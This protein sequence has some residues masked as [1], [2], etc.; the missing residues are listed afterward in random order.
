M[1]V[2]KSKNI[3]ANVF[4]F[5]NPICYKK[6]GR[7]LLKIY[8]GKVVNRKKTY[9]L[10]LGRVKLGVFNSVQEAKDFNIN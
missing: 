6:V 5:S 9:I 7:K 8:T 1:N 3:K 2:F 4:N 10:S